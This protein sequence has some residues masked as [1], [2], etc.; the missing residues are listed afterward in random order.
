M[1][2]SAGEMRMLGT[3][4]LE[5][6][7]RDA[8]EHD[9][10]LS[11]HGGRIAVTCEVDRS[12]VLEGEAESVAAK[13]IAL[14]LAASVPGS[15]GIVDRLRVKPSV[16]MG[17]GE[18][19]DRVRDAL[20]QEPVFARCAIYVGSDTLPK[21][22][23]EPAAPSG[24][25]LEAAVRDGVVTLNG[26]VKSLSHKRLAGVLAWWVP[27]TRDV[28]NGIDVQPL[29]EDSDDEITDA[30]RN[31]L[32]KDKLISSEVIRV[33]T[34]SAVVTLEGRAANADQAAMAEADAWYV[35]GVDGVINHLQIM[36]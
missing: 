14:E 22:E 10:R 33:R 4:E 20:L 3:A 21:R 25:Y 8:L 9:P 19:R 34:R 28:V 24:D 27:G 17:D 13:K 2:N 11:M 7:V 26:R 30:V 23:R 31:A 6:Q 1:T 32:E 36:E 15:A 35:F 16:R 12:L 29:E 18:I 5:R